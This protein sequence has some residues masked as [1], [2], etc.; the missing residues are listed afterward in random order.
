V[1]LRAAV[2]I[3]CGPAD[4]LAGDGCNFA[5]TEDQEADQ[6]RSWTPFCPFEIDMRQTVSAVPHGQLEGGQRIRDGGAA[7]SEDA[8]TAVLNFTH[9]LKLAVEFGRKPRG[10]S[11]TDTAK[12]ATETTDVTAASRDPQKMATTRTGSRY[13]TK[14]LNTGTC[15]RAR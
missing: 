14:R 3:R 11:N 9:D 15:A 2:S 13:S 12:A 6:V 1:D 7:E 4:D 8:I 10:G 5:H